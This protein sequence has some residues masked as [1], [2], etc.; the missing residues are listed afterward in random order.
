VASA[1]TVPY[2]VMPY[3]EGET[4]RDRLG[5]TG[6]MRTAEAVRLTVEI[7][8]ALAKAHKTGIVYRDIRH[9]DPVD[10]R[11]QALGGRCRVAAHK[12]L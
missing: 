8:N 2:Y 4:L 5:R 11:T 10:R 7:A 1:E 12:Q 6:T 9:D 3:V